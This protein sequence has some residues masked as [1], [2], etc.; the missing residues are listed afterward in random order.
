MM[1][2]LPVEQ[3]D[4]RAEVNYLIVPDFTVTISS[5][6]TSEGT[7]DVASVTVDEGTSIS[8]SGNKLTI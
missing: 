3:P 8:A 6:S 4:Q 7:V 2:G 1:W 5:S